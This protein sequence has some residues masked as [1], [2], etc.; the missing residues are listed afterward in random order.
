M[1]RDSLETLHELR[2]E[3][4]TIALTAAIAEGLATLGQADAALKTID[5]IISLAERNAPHFAMPEL[6]RIKGNI[7]I[8]TPGSDLSEAEEYFLNSLDLAGR[9]GAL[10][11]EL[12]AATS[13]ASLMTKLGRPEEGRKVI[14][15]V[16]DRFSEGFD[17]SDLQAATRLMHQLGLPSRNS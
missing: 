17:N 12:R 7:L 2:Y 15:P 13:L 14:A 9:Q 10:A 11:L 5:E 4:S 8:S 16:Y 6:L 3:L 1:L